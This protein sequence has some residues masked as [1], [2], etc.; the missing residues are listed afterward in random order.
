MSGEEAVLIRSKRDRGFFLCLVR[1]LAAVP[2]FALAAQEADVLGSDLELR[3][4]RAILALEEARAAGGLVGLESAFHQEEL[5]FGEILGL[6]L[7]PFFPQEH[8]KP[9]GMAAPSSWGGSCSTLPWRP[10]L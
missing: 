1:G 8:A 9:S 10:R 3:A 4:R 2:F 7:S 5:P 6:P